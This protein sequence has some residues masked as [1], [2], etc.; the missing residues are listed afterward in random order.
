MLMS[1]QLDPLI[2]GAKTKLDNMSHTDTNFFMKAERKKL[3]LNCYT[4]VKNL[5]NKKD[6]Y[7]KSY[8]DTDTIRRIIRT[9]LISNDHTYVNINFTI[10]SISILD[11]HFNNNIYL[12]KNK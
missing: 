12:I 5:S 4:I 11:D 6:T 8:C 3:R 7:I 10:K 2:E 9:Y 1:S